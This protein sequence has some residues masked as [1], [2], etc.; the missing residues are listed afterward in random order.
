MDEHWHQLLKQKWNGI[1]LQPR[2][3]R[4]YLHAPLWLQLFQRAAAVQDQLVPHQGEIDCTEITTP[5][6]NSCPTRW[7]TSAASATTRRGASSYPASPPTRWTGCLASSATAWWTSLRGEHI[8]WQKVNILAIS[9]DPGILW[10]T[11]P[12]SS[13]HV[14]TQHLAFQWV[15]K[16]EI[17]EN[18]LLHNYR[19]RWSRRAGSATCPRYAW[20]AWRAGPRGCSVA[21]NNASSSGT[22]ANS[23][24]ARCTPTTFL[25]PFPAVQIVWR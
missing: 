1:V 18:K 6:I 12:F 19:P 14:S 25:P 22:G 23:S 9:V 2:Q 21:T 4:K 13:L 10:S 24:W 3:R 11:A 16:Y 5:M 15:C 17:P 8:N 20:A 7:R